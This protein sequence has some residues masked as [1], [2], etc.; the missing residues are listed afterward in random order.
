MFEGTGKIY[1]EG[2]EVEWNGLVRFLFHFT[3]LVWD[4]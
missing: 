1:M 4:Y 3:L 2:N